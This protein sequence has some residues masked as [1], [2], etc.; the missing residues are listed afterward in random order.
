MLFLLA[1][2]LPIQRYALARSLASPPPRAATI[3]QDHTGITFV[4]NDARLFR[5]CR[6]KCH[7]NVRTRP[8]PA[9]LSCQRCTN[10]LRSQF[11]MKRN[12]RKVRASRLHN[13]PLPSPPSQHQLTP[14]FPPT[15]EM[16]QSLPQI[17]RQRDARRHDAHV[18][19]PTQRARALQPRPRRHH[20]QGH[21]A[22][23]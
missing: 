2:M 20:A 4:R 11:K 17:R 10:S 16:D 14:P 7:K 21:A 15:A 19:G 1:A 13:L 3:S 12:P 18:R 23:G 6:S 8:H 9:P 22:R 5:F